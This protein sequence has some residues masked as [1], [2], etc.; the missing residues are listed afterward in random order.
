MTPPTGATA[1][2]NQSITG[3][4]ME[5]SASDTQD[6]DDSLTVKFTL[7]NSERET[8]WTDQRE[9][10]WPA[11][12]K[13]IT[14]HQEGEK[15]GTCFTPATFKS[16]GRRNDEVNEIS[17]V[18]FDSDCGH[19]MEEIKAAIER[20]G[21][22]ATIA[23]THSHLKEE[24]ETTDEEL[25]KYGWSCEDVLREGRGIL[26]HLCTGAT[27]VVREDKSVAIR[28]Q[29]V[30]KYRI[31]VPLAGPF[32]FDD[33]PTPQ[34]AILAWKGIYTDL[35]RRLDLRVDLKCADPAR[36]FY[37]A[38][39]EAG[40]PFEILIIG[41]SP[42]VIPPA[43][44]VPHDGNRGTELRERLDPPTILEGV[45]EGERDD[46][47]YKFACRLE[48]KNLDRAEAETLVLAA[49]AKCSPPFPREEALRKVESA[50]KHR[51]ERGFQME[52]E[53]DFRINPWPIL[54][55]KALSGI[56][57]KFVELATRNSE[58]DPAAVLVTF[59]VRAGIEFGTGPHLMIGDAKH[60]ARLNAV[61]VGNSSKAR[62][63]TSGKPISRLFRFDAQERTADDPL[64][65]VPARETPGPL[66]SGEGLIWNVRDLVK[67]WLVDKKTGEGMD[68]IDDPGVDDKR[69]FVLDEELAA[70]LQST[71]R[72]GNT[73][74]V[75]IRSAF[76][77]G[78][79]EPL[80]KSS[81]ITA[82]GAHIGIVSHIT[83]AEL[84]R[85]L[86]ETQALN[87][88]ANRFLWICA[89]RQ[90]LVPFPEPMPEEE[91]AEIQKELLRIF[92]TVGSFGRISLSHE[93]KEFWKG[94]YAKLSE[95]KPG[96]VGCVTGRG[97]A[98]VARMALVYALIDA[99]NAIE[100]PH[101][102][103]ALAIWSY[104]RQ[105]AEYIFS[106]REANPIAEKIA[107]ACGEGPLSLTDIH[108][109]LSNNATKA[110]IQTA[111]QDLVTSGRVKLREERT[112]RKPKKLISLTN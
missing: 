32:C 29:P 13:V 1:G 72:E 112:G 81:R 62:K 42:Y 18:V 31:V 2:G 110:A 99:C 100:V 7:A 5:N 33:Y 93:A 37:R 23:S 20:E 50:W 70:A 75:I 90:E 30:S 11:F 84:H 53:E 61:I 4:K 35:A 96:L 80:T 28:H 103:S 45:P 46:V 94:G 6:Q 49:A 58:A 59:L 78:N 51:A 109:R 54:P 48:G 60:H 73:L 56:T 16:G 9:R 68:I 101:L 106:G 39:H 77:H 102:E 95:E 36:L 76:D 57:G 105:S 64:L 69:M 74:S 88:F 92:A 98:L 12:A 15:S 86:D 22:A 91:L 111:V 8:N 44:L 65:Y 85:L 108:R 40:R 63:G 79:L 10:A 27:V 3:L 19:P 47:L 17:M 34:A 67:K 104:A 71:K 97:E 107:K 21:L 25:E 24:T 43:R 82:T 87:G 38:R 26:P 41:G 14:Q 66:S 83:T 55:E 52:S 89:R